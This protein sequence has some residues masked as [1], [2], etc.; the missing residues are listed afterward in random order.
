MQVQVCKLSDRGRKW[1]EM[2][3]EMNEEE[4]ELK[5]SLNRLVQASTLR[6]IIVQQ[7]VARPGAWSGSGV[8]SQPSYPEHHPPLSQSLAPLHSQD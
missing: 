6:A 1:I 7:S 8:P 3:D 2:K 5:L 4:F